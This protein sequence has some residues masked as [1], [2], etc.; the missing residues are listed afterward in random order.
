MSS[1]T[2]SRIS[3]LAW[4][5]GL[6]VILLLA[7]RFICTS[8]IAKAQTL[9]QQ[10]VKPYVFATLPH[11]RVYKTVHE[12]CELFITESDVNIPGGQYGFANGTEFYAVTT[13][14]GC[15]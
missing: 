3:F 12:G 7:F 5:I 6:S 1:L 9:E 11:G 2:R 14:R 15:K 4:W 10:E 13:G 8:L